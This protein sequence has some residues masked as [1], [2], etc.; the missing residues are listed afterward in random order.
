MMK[1]LENLSC[2]ERLRELGLFSLEKGRLRGTLSISVNTWKE[3]VPIGRTRGNGHKLKHR[4]F[5]LNIRKHFFTVRVTKDR[6]PRVSLLG[7]FE[8]PSGRGPEQLALAVKGKITSK[9]AATVAHHG[10][11]LP[12]ALPASGQGCQS[13][14]SLAARRHPSHGGMGHYQPSAHCDSATASL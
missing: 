9:G 5:P 1:E 8:K 3:V 2:E 13:H 14:I 10:Q 7:D 4:S 12:K 6:F 11:P